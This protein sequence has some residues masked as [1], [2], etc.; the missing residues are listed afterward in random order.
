ME[1]YNG[2]RFPTSLA[3]LSHD[4]GE[5]AAAHVPFGG[6]AQESGGNGRDHVVNDLIGD[7]FVEFSFVAKAPGVHLQ[8]FQL[9]ATLVGNVVDDQ[10]REVRLA[11]HGAKASKF[12]Y[13]DMDVKVPI[14][15]RVGEGV[16]SIGWL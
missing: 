9:Y 16:E 6:D 12:G 5:N 7:C 1:V 11:G 13:F 10:H 8:A 2:Q 15:T 14:G 3:M 4:V